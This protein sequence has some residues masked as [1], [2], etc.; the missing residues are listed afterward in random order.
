MDNNLPINDDNQNT[1]G[2]DAVTP[3]VSPQTPS[4]SSTTPIDNISGVEGAPVVETIPQVEKPASIET[5]PASIET[6]ASP[7]IPMAPAL[8]EQADTSPVAPK[9][10]PIQ[11]TPVE[12]NVVDKRTNHEPLTKIDSTADALTVEA[13]AE[14]EDFIKHV[15]E[16]HT[17]KQ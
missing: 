2:S 17:I 3:S 6:V 16:V 12:L 9:P 7:E 13:D 1:I 8:S 10:E 15:E 5:T 4:T 11:K 14:E